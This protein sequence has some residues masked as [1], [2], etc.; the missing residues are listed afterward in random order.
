MAWLIM[1]LNLPITRWVY[2]SV[3]INI[4]RYS[5][6]TKENLTFSLHFGAMAWEDLPLNEKKAHRYHNC[7]ECL[8]PKHLP[9][10][11]LLR[12]NAQRHAKNVQKLPPVLTSSLAKCTEASSPVTALKSM[13]QLFSNVS[14]YHDQVFKKNVMEE[15]RE[16][17]P[18]EHCQKMA[19]RLAQ[20]VG[21]SVVEPIN[22]ALLAKNVSYQAISDIFRSAKLEEKENSKFSKYTIKEGRFIFDR[23]G[24][25]NAVQE[26][27]KAGTKI[28]WS[29]LSRTHKVLQSEYGRPALNASMF[30]K[31]YAISEGLVEKSDKQIVRRGKRKI[32]VGGI[33]VDL[34]MIFPT[35]DA[36]KGDTRS[37]IAAG[38]WDIGTPIVPITLHTKRINRHGIVET[39]SQTLS[40]RAYSLQKIMDATLVAHDE[41]GFLRQPFPADYSLSTALKE[42]AGLGEQNYIIT[43]TSPSFITAIS[44]VANIFF[45]ITC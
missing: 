16:Q 8:T 43:T 18:P 30:L 3:T 24:V 35:D 44:I 37:K 42:L 6:T 31:A 36:L 26:K 7:N 2:N 32:D 5:Y 25:R 9:Y 45:K 23:D 33:Q 40:G 39:V 29:E 38:V 28:N 22:K 41:A 27:L 1:F 15:A 10:Y 19:N 4:F 11:K 14:E 17:N 12:R 20:E 34:T 21:K 13:D